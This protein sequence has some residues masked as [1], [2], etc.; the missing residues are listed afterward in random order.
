L[1]QKALRRTVIVP[2]DVGVF[3]EFVLIAHAF[4]LLARDEVVFA[5]VLFRSAWRARGVADGEIQVGD[6]L[7]DLIHQRRLSRPRRRGDNEHQTVWLL[8]H[9]TFC[10]CSRDFSISDFIV[11]PSSVM[12]RPSPLTP[13][14]LESSVLA[15]RFISCKRKSSFLPTSPP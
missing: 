10:A 13:A 7:A 11:R 2:E 6:A 4:E 12:R 5:A 14:V 1:A 8:A 15:S 9:S 3:E